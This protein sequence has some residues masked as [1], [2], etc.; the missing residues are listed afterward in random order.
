MNVKTLSEIMGHVSSKTALDIYLHSTDAMKQQVANK[1]DR[2]F[3][4][5]TPTDKKLHS[6]SKKNSHKPDLSRERAKFAKEGQVVSA[7]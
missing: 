2:H 7:K 6:N 4:K 1:I 5:N 3:D